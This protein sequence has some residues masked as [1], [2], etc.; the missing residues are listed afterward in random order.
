MISALSAILVSVLVGQSDP[1]TCQG[2]H[3][4]GATLICRTDPGARVSL[5]DITVE[6][7]ENGFVILGH[8]RDAEPEAVLRVEPAEG[9]AFEQTV[10]SALAMVGLWTC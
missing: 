5:G 4:Q 6:A 2:D 7:N 8:D 10:D 1:I 9:E 3:I